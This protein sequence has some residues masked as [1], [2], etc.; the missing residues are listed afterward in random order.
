MIV[1]SEIMVYSK[2]VF[3]RTADGKHIPTTLSRVVT[4][5]ERDELIRID[6][7]EAI[8]HGTTVFNSAK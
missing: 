7:Q 3:I 4:E 8:N 5:I 6:R 2:T 1:V